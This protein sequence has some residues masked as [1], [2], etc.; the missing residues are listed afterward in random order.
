MEEGALIGPDRG[1]RS[2]G[3]ASGGS[4]H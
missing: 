1:F 3:R 2:N 4:F